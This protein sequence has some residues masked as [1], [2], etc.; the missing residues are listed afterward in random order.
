MKVY[1]IR[2]LIYELPHVERVECFKELRDLL[3]L[4]VVS[5]SRR[6]HRQK[7]SSIDFK[8]NELPLI[9]ATLSKYLKRPVYVDDLYN[10]PAKVTVFD[11][12][13]TICS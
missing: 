1:K 13:N 2:D 6:I 10:N 11:E 8:G 12:Q 9:A 4:D 7:N 5:F 3:S